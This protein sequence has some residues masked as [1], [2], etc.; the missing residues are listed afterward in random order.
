[1]NKSIERRW[2]RLWLKL[3][4]G[5][6]LGRFAS[7]MA[8][9]GLPA[10]YGKLPLA[11]L[12][13][14]GYVS[15]DARIAHRQLTIGDHCFVSGGVLI[16]EERDSGTVELGARV[17]VHEAVTIQTGHGGSLSIGDDTH[18]QPRCQFSAYRGRIEIGA[19]CEI[20]PNCAFY[21]YNHGMDAAIAMQ[22][23]P[24]YSRGG[25][26]VGD[27][28]W[29]GFGVI[30]LDGIGIGRGAV[31]AAGAVVTTDIPDFGIAAGVPARV[32]GSRLDDKWRAAPG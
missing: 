32:V 22:Q 31:V 12:H 3:A 24:T 25:I 13:R 17:H 21:P 18:V 7:R 28:A 11:T 15:P 10:A 2:R 16:Y 23:Q 5:T 6:P 1:M 19:R 9:L 29:L 30:L 20:A 8:G 4:H 14:R 26:R 27:E